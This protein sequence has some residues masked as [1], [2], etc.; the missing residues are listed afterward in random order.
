MLVNG[1][2]CEEGQSK[3]CPK[4]EVKKGMKKTKQDAK[5]S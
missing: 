5:E 1:G 4:T 3:N 2:G